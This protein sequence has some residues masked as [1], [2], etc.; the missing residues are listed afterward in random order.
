MTARNPY[1][2]KVKDVLSNEVVTV[3]PDDTLQAALELMTESHLTALP[4]ISAEERCVGILS[5]SDVVEMARTMNEETRGSA[6][7]DVESYQSV[8]DSVADHDLARRTVGEFMTDSVT[9]VTG[10]ITL[11]AAASEMLRYHVHRLPVLDEDGKLLGIISTM[12]ILQA[13]VAGAPD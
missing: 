13:F 2:L 3:S 5:A 6:A 10:D 1:Y 4:V 12:D 8:Y 9:T 7:G 11:S